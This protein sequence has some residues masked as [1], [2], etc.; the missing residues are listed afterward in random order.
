M[1][2]NKIDPQIWKSVTII[3]AVIGC[4]GVLG[5]AL[6]GILPDILRPTPN[7]VVTEAINSP[8]ETQSNNVESSM[9][10]YFSDEFT[11]SGSYDS[12]LWD[13]HNDCGS[14]NIF[15]RDG[16]LNLKRNQEGWS[17]LLSH[18]VWLYSRLI[19]LEGRL[20]ISSNTNS[21]VGWLYI[22][23]NAGCQINGSESPSIEC[24]YGPADNRE[25]ASGEQPIRFD[26]W[27]RM[28]IEFGQESHLVRYYLDDNL[29]GQYSPKVYPETARISLG[30]ISQNGVTNALVYIDNVKLTLSK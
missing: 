1:T 9:V 10:S 22:D 21:G 29:I 19:S 17:S 23:N 20:Q 12:G 3:V 13:C 25:Y 14:E 24:Y 8:S 27:Y 30:I 2:D 7:I 6:I 15:L 28:R 11:S 26:T 18:S 4:I 5:A 16:S